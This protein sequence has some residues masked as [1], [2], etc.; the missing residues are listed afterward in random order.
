[1]VFH[2]IQPEQMTIMILDD[3]P[4]VTE[5]ILAARFVQNTFAIFRRENDVINDL[6]V[7]GQ[8]VLARFVRPFQGRGF[9][10]I[11]RRLRLRLPVF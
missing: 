10:V 3:A 2:A 1:M 11:N 8:N 7:G 5:Q 6:C 4:D 9:F